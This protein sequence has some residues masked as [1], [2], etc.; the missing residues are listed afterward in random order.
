MKGS[1]RVALTYLA[2]FESLNPGRLVPRGSITPAPVVWQVDEIAWVCFVFLAA[3][4][5]MVKRSSTDAATLFI[6][7]QQDQ[8]GRVELLAA[9]HQHEFNLVEVKVTASRR[10]EG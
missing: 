9:G 1:L 3:N 2:H 10:Q 4:W 5:K 7:C 8:E 6:E